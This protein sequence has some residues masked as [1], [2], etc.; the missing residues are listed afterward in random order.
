MRLSSKVSASEQQHTVLST[1][2]SLTAH[3]CTG[4]T[5]RRQ[6]APEAVD[7]RLTLEN[8]RVNTGDRPPAHPFPWARASPSVRRHRVKLPLGALLSSCVHLSIGLVYL[9]ASFMSVCFVFLYVLCPLSSSA[10]LCASLCF[11][12]FL[13]G[14]V[15]YMCL[16]QFCMNISL[17]LCMSVRTSLCVYVIACVCV[18]VC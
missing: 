9:R 11:C 7:T 13:R 8:R 18:C 1:V 15:Y 6:R 14:H 10:P 2:P 12:N 16:F 5:S 17:R 4:S 3:G